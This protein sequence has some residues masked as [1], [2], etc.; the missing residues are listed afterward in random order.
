M[1]SASNTTAQRSAFEGLSPRSKRG[2][3]SHR[4]AEKQKA[5]LTRQ[6]HKVTGDDGQAGRL[7][8][9][10]DRC[11][12]T[13]PCW[14]GAC[15]T[16]CGVVSPHLIQIM[17]RF[18]NRRKTKGTIVAISVVVPSS[19]VEIG[20]L[21][22]FNPVNFARRLKYVF[23]KAGV[24]WVIGCFDYSVNFHKNN[25][26]E[27]HWCAHLHGFTVTDD[28]QALRCALVKAVKKTDAIPR[29]VR[30]K[31]WDGSKKAIR[32]ALK[33]RF[34]R[35][36]GIDDAKRFNVK[37]GKVRTCRATKKQRLLAAERI[38]LALHLDRI[39]WEGRLFMRHVQLRRTQ[40]GP[41]IALINNHAGKSS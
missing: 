38:E 36:Q 9:K 14:S 41:T 10:L 37:T 28:P 19:V 16:C 5:K 15:Q 7:A 24:T 25:R 4:R 27:P 8:K 12:P 26:Y 6:L 21:N 17:R 20:A 34:Y 33:T 22:Q 1:K 30:V 40:T 18:L 35:R 2:H 32:Y 3:R 13:N 29:P 23:D 39:G 11:L 31:P